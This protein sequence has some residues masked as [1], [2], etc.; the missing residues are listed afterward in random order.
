MALRRKKV[1]D[2]VVGVVRRKSN[3]Q[4]VL[5]SKAVD[6]VTCDLAEGI[7]RSEAVIIATP[8]GS[9]VE[10]IKSLIALVKPGTVITD[11]GSAKAEIVNA[12]E[13]II[14]KGVFF[15]G[16]HPLAGSEKSGIEHARA[17]IFDKALCVLTTT[18]KTNSRAFRKI[19][20]LW[21]G[22]GVE[23]RVLSP[24]DHDLI[25]GRTSHAPHLAAFALVSLLQNG[26]ESFV[27]GGFR[28][29]TRIASSN[30]NLWRDIFLMNRKGVL[31]GVK[32]LDICIKKLSRLIDRQEQEKL[33]LELEKIQSRREKL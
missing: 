24:N 23:V 21:E 28:D 25:L 6:E 18:P 13:K 10:Q 17:D 2:K 12:V 26:D 27:A 30:A 8:V 14:P 31:K 32:E 19:R 9:V 5:D 1:A 33:L 3:I 4:K 20:D 22:L 7:G 16:G 11:V 15:V 29:T